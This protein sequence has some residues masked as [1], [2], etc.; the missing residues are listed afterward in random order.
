MIADWAGA[1][2]EFSEVP[3]VF[4][5]FAK[6]TEDNVVEIAIPRTGANMGTD[7]RPWLYV[8]GDEIWDN[9]EYVPSTIVE[10]WGGEE[11]EYYS[12]NYNLLWGIVRLGDGLSNLG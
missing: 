10:G 6:N 3:E 2:E 7:V 4:A 12:I 8:V 9:E 5:M 1:F 11:G